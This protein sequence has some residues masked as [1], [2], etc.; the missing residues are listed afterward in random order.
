M[1]TNSIH[2]PKL[3]KS[4]TLGENNSTVILGF[5]PEVLSKRIPPNIFVS[6][7][8]ICREHRF[9]RRSLSRRFGEA[10]QGN[11]ENGLNG[12]QSTPP[13]LKMYFLLKMEIFQ[14]HVSF[15]GCNNYCTVSL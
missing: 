3:S 9:T 7:V 12:S 8:Y 2:V 13:H 6:H 15:Q 14:C 4:I 11:I 5:L 10:G 1:Q